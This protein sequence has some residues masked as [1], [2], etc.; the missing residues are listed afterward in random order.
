MFVYVTQDDQRTMCLT[1]IS[2]SFVYRTFNCFWFDSKGNS[3]IVLVRVGI[4]IFYCINRFHG[5]GLFCKFLFFLFC[6]DRYAVYI[7]KTLFRL[8]RHMHLR[9]IISISTNKIKCPEW[10]IRFIHCKLRTSSN[11]ETLIDKFDVIYN[12]VEGDRKTYHTD[13]RKIESNR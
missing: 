8:I 2:L 11:N 12:T 10:M 1:W 4:F 13:H 7:Y 5:N 9:F 6:I 3:I